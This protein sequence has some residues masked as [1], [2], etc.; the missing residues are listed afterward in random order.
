MAQVDTWPGPGGVGPG[1]DGGAVAG[2]R[3]IFHA[4]L[5]VPTGDAKV[6]LIEDKSV[7]AATYS[8]LTAGCSTNR[9]SQL[10]CTANRPPRALPRRDAASAAAAAANASGAFKRVGGALDRIPASVL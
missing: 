7:A 9:C 1:G 8:Q 4:D 10:P 6:A 3:T 5:M 2:H